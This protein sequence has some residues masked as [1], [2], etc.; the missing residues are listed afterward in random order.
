MGS[1]AYLPLVGRVSPVP[2]RFNSET[3]S[4]A[5]VSDCSV[6]IQNWELDLQILTDDGT[7]GWF[8]LER[9]PPANP[10]W[11]FLVN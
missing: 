8:S 4:L 3:P 7:E 10:T 6:I 2:I 9:V 11:K 1:L 5:D